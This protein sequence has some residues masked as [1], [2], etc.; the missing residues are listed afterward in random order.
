MRKEAIHLTSMLENTLSANLG[1][2][3]TLFIATLLGWQILEPIHILW[4]NLVTD[5]FPAIALGMEEA[6]KDSMDYEPRSP[7]SS[8]LSKGVLPSIIYQGIL[9]GA[10]TLIVYWFVLDHY[11]PHLAQ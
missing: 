2:V 6:E 9:E 5:V 10:V 7:E 8:F 1:E 4:I 11:A 3:L